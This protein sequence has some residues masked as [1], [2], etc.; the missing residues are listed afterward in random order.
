MGL[1]RD[2][3][4]YDGGGRGG[5]VFLLRRDGRFN[6]GGGRGGTAYIIM[7]EGRVLL[8]RLLKFHSHV[9]HRVTSK[10]AIWKVVGVFHTLSVTPRVPSLGFP[11][12]CSP[13]AIDSDERLE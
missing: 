9:F 4:F 6:D 10:P 5:T 3:Y 13:V 8:R 1:P 2:V 7:T 11:V 12:E